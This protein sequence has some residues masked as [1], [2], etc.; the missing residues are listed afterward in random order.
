MY[1]AGVGKQCLAKDRNRYVVE[2]VDSAP[3]GCKPQAHSNKM[4]VDAF[5]V[6][7]QALQLDDDAM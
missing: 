5:P 4:K 7:P 1:R 6:G 2:L 3:S